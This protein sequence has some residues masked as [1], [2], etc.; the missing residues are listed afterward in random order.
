[1]RRLLLGDLVLCVALNCTS[2]HTDVPREVNT[3]RPF[4]SRLHIDYY[5]NNHF[6]QLRSAS[7][8]DCCFMAVVSCGEPHGPR[9]M[10]NLRERTMGNE[11]RQNEDCSYPKG[12][13]VLLRETARKVCADPENVD[14]PM[15]APQ[16]CDVLQSGRVLELQNRDFWIR[17]TDLSWHFPIIVTI[18]KMPF[19]NYRGKSLEKLKAREDKIEEVKKQKTLKNIDEDWNSPKWKQSWTWT[20]SYSSSSSAWRDWSSDQTRERVV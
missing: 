18:R 11:K 4:K 12:I 17:P 15:I 2:Q 9:I 16:D 3:G 6:S 7:D 10:R 1:M 5:H 14:N 8:L 13:E 19:K 20:T